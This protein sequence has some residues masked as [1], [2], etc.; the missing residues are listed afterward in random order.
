[1]HLTQKHQKRI[2]EESYKPQTAPSLHKPQC[3]HSVYAAWKEQTYKQPT[4]TSYL[5]AIH[6]SFCVANCAISAARVG[7]TRTPCRLCLARLRRQGYSRWPWCRD[8]MQV[9]YELYQKIVL[10]LKHR[11]CQLLDTYTKKKETISKFTW[12]YPYIRLEDKRYM[13][14]GPA[15]PKFQILYMIRTQKG[16]WLEKKVLRSP[17]LVGGCSRRYYA[18]TWLPL[19]DQH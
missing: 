7:C 1:M 2:P 17:V 10:T 11:K 8:P 4:T 18:L 5:R 16:Q 12:P 13:A 9:V 14:S 15:K 3:Q 6:Q 19:L